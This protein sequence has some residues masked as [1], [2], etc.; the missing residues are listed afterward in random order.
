MNG[1]TKRWLKCSVYCITFPPSLLLQPSP[2]SENNGVENEGT[3]HVLTRWERHWPQQ[4]SP[5]GAATVQ[6]AVCTISWWHTFL[7][8]KKT[9]I[10]LNLF[11]VKEFPWGLTAISG[12]YQRHNFFF[13]FLLLPLGKYSVLFSSSHKSLLS[14]I[15]LYTKLI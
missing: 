4:S 1:K 10:I 7:Q 14:L 11:S 12:L 15:K 8:L 13:F 6:A 2:P 3:S 9:W 5:E